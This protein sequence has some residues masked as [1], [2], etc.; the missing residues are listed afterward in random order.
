[1]SPLFCRA[2]FWSGSRNPDA[3]AGEC[4]RRDTGQGLPETPTGLFPHRPAGRF[5]PAAAY[6]IKTT[7]AC[8]HKIILE[9]IVARDDQDSTRSDLAAPLRRHLHRRRHLDLTI[10]EVIERSERRRGDARNSLTPREPRH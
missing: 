3:A 1:M 7:G 6:E 4:S 5:R 8:P 2:A 9:A 10:D